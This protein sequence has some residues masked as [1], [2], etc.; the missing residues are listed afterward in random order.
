LGA[1][2]SPGAEAARRCWTEGH[3]WLAETRGFL[4][5]R[6][7]QLAKRVADDLPGVSLQSPEATYLAWLDFTALELEDEPREWLFE[8][9][10]VAL[11]PGPDFGQSG[12]GF[13]RINT[14]TSAE[15]LDEL[16]DRIS[17]ALRAR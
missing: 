14:A 15:L 9:A 1:V 10:K 3:D 6:R 13:V 12:A 8:H 16:V 5:D 2:G 7:D 4:T 11:S 17:A